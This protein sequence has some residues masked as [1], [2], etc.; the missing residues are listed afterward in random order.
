[1]RRCGRAD[2]LVTLVALAAL[3]AWDATGWDLAFARWYGTAA[4]FVWRDAW[5]TRSLLH[6]GGRW[7]AWG[8]LGLLVLDAVR[9]AGSGPGRAERWWWIAVMLA[10]ALL[11]PSIKQIST[12]SCPWELAE[13]G[14]VARYVSHWQFGSVDGG[15]GHCFPSGHA[16][17]AFAFLGVYFLWRPYR[18]LLAVCSL[19]AV[20]LAGA[21]FGW[22]QLA[23]GAHYPSHTLWSAWLCWTLCVIGDRLLRRSTRH[24]RVVDGGVDRLVGEGSR[25]C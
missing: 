16:V 19:A 11:V 9:P 3:L 2:L 18:P 6:D 8:L 1:M 12:T 23:R 14:G 13:F 4:G 25:P 22:A 15:P 5:L 24:R 20:L 7:L 17:A 10:G 21:A